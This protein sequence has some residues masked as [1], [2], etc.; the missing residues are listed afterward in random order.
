[1]DNTD[2]AVAA[3]CAETGAIVTDYTAAPVYFSEDS[4]GAHE[5]L[6]EFE[7]AP[8]DFEGF[9]TALD[10]A[11]RCSNS[12]YDAKRTKDIALRQPIVNPVPK[13][14]FVN[15]LSSKGK[16]G[17]QHKVPRL[18]NDRTFLEEIKTFVAASQK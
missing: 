16:L 1:M 18:S 12:D 15:W 17:G 7:R 5:M 2:Q 14:S 9:V 8:S 3:A 13:H 10:A 6:V 4:N 11:L